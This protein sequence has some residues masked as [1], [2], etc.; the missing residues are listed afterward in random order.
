MKRLIAAIL[1]LCMCVGFYG[2][3]DAPN[4]PIGT[5]QPVESL[6]EPSTESTIEATIPESKDV[7]LQYN[8]QIEIGEYTISFQDVLFSDH[9]Y[10]YGCADDEIF[11]TVFATIE[12]SGRTETR[13][14][15]QLLTLVYGDGYTFKPEEV[16]YKDAS[17]EK[18]SSNDNELKPMCEPKNIQMRFDIPRKTIEEQEA[19][20]V[21]VN[22][23]P[24]GMTE[25][26][27]ITFNI[28]PTSESEKAVLYDH[29]TSCF[30]QYDE[31][32]LFTPLAFFKALGDYKDSTAWLEK[33]EIT[34]RFYEFSSNIDYFNEHLSE[35]Q[36]LTGSEIEQIIVGERYGF[37]T[38]R[39][40]DISADG[41]IDD[42]YFYY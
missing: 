23:E 4:E 9:W 37:G 26:A 19:M 42:G 28:Y 14:P 34:Q 17:D 8:E 38:G 41:T 33:T 40:W 15:G 12:Y 20:Y 22:T 3:S 5:T 11:A 39:T 24:L 35:Y 10:S 27:T 7:F 36:V 1:L 6:T 32:S 13:T 31:E 30:I 25:D 21:S 18:Y 2:C 29:I 16:Y